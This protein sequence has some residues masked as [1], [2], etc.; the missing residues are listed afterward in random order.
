MTSQISK[1]KVVA[2]IVALVVFQCVC[3]GQDSQ[4]ILSGI[5]QLE[6]VEAMYPEKVEP[7]FQLAL[8]CLNYSVMNPHAEQTEGLLTKAAQKI[9]ALE[10]MDGSDP[11]DICTLKG[12]FYMVRIV[13]DPAKNGQ[14]YYL[15]V[16]QY[17]E[18]ALKLN[19]ENALAG[20]LQQ[21]F[22]EGMKNAYICPKK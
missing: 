12:F 16:M 9:D 2:I 5:A 14:R 15:D 8:Q 19:P 20:Q 17:F 22:L 11:S 18:K 4:A 3:N 1:I 7:K 10:Q 21:K 6:R 13:Q